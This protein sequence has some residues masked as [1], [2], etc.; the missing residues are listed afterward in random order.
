MLHGT[1]WFVVSSPTASLLT[2][3]TD[4]G[5]LSVGATSDVLYA[6]VVCVRRSVLDGIGRR[7]DP[8]TVVL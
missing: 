1:L 7:V 6:S 5:A 4:V 8:P 2:E 3:R